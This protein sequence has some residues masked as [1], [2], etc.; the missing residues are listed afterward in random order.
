MSKSE[1][2]TPETLASFAAG[3][4]SEAA[5]RAT[6]RHLSECT[7]CR[8]QV[9]LLS[10][11]EEEDLPM[12][13]PPPD[14]ARPD[15]PRPASPWIL[16]LRLTAALLIFG[17]I[18]WALVMMNRASKPD[19]PTPIPV[20][21]DPEAAPQVPEAPR[22]KPDLPAPD[23]EPEPETTPAP[24]PTPFVPTPEPAPERKPAPPAPERKIARRITGD[25]VEAVEISVGAGDIKVVRRDTTTELAERKYVNP[26]DRL[27]AARPASIVLPDGATVHLAEDSEVSVSWSQR[28]LCYVVDLRRGRALVDLG[29]EPRGVIVAGGAPGIRLEEA[30]GQLLLV[31]DEGLRATPLDGP[32]GFR[33]P[34]GADQVLRPNETLVLGRVEDRIVAAAAPKPFDSLFPTLGAPAPAPAPRPKAAPAAAGLPDP[35]DLAAALGGSTYRFRVSRRFVR[36]GVWHPSGI[37]VSFVDQ[38]QAVSRGGYQQAAHLRRGSRPWDDLGRIRPK[39]RQERV[40]TALR[41]AG[42]PHVQLGEALEARRGEP[43]V[44]TRAILGRTCRVTEHDLE[45]ES[46][47]AAMDRLIQ[48]AVEEGRLARPSRIYWKTLEGTVEIAFTKSGSELLRAVDRRRVAYSTNSRSGLIRRWYHV[49]TVYEFTDHGEATLRLPEAILRELDPR[50]K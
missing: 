35:I 11:S 27:Q 5:W 4:A 1:C 18:A 16:P 34:A 40:V 33:S 26:S 38:F 28:L 14:V 3:A 30:A 22:P 46:T 25:I 21:G 41:N 49:E 44:R 48:R 36:N 9:S 43:R 32:A 20:A 45:P 19:N 13:G 12:T 2:P 24:P 8:R 47:R 39:S 7:L 31:N 15:R 50:R 10:L 42:A 29:A 23:P 6:I 37:F 17:A